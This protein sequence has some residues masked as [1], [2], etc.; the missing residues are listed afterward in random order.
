VTQYPIVIASTFWARVNLLKMGDR[1]KGK[2]DI[3]TGA[4]SVPGPAD[5]EQV[6]NVR[7]GE[8]HFALSLR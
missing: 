5:R 1:L 7:I 6:S 3:V 4:G 2:V 8:T